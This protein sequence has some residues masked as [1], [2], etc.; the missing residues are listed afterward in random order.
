MENRKFSKRLA[1]KIVQSGL[2]ILTFYNVHKKQYAFF[3]IS[4]TILEHFKL[5]IFSV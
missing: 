2:D 4:S 5:K 3:N 1:E